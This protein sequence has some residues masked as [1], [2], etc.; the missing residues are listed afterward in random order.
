MGV[1]LAASGITVP[2]TAKVEP[3]IVDPALDYP[4]PV[5]DLVSVSLSVAT[6][7]T[8]QQLQITFEASADISLEARTLMTGYNL[9]GKVGSCDLIASFLSYPMALEASGQFPAGESDA[10]CGE[11]GRNVAGMFKLDGS[12]VT[13]IFPLRDLKGIAVGAPMN[14]LRAYTA[15]GQGFAGDDTG[16]LANTGDGAASDKAHTLPPA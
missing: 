11:G 1:S 13:A 4:I 2:S 5:A 9:R 8:G 6:A 3:Q 12:S 10:Q 15:L 7:R 16:L 14:D